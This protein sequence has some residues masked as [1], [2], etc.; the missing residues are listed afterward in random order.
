VREYTRGYVQAGYRVTRVALRIRS[1]RR[2]PPITLIEGEGSLVSQR[3]AEVPRRSAASPAGPLVRIVV[4]IVIFLAGVAAGLASHYLAAKVEI[5]GDDAL[6]GTG[7]GWRAEVAQFLKLYTR[8]TLDNLPDDR[9][10]RQTELRSIGR[11]LGLGLSIDKVSLDGLV[12]R[13]SQLLNCI[14]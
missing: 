1:M 10:L 2:E 7:G 9:S 4:A 13:H 6:E 5:D 14:S 12:L 3:P 8:D 11:K